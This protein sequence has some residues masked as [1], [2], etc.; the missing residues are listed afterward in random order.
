MTETSKPACVVLG[1]SGTIG[2]AVCDSLAP[3]WNVLG[4][5]RRG[6]PEDLLSTGVAELRV[7][8][9]SADA[10]AEI[11]G[12][13]EQAGWSCDALVVASGIHEVS[14]LAECDMGSVERMFA[15]NFLGP[16]AVTRVLLPAMSARRTGS[17]VWVSSVRGTHGDPGQ[18]VYAATKGAMNSA[19]YSLAREVGRRNVRA[20]IVAPGVVRSPMTDVLSYS[21][22]ESLIARNPMGR[23]AYPDEVATV[24][25]WLAGP[26]SS[27]VTGTIINVDC[28]EVAAGLKEPARQ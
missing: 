27:Y 7:D 25:R 1:A 18:V 21:W 2:S 3:Q 8:I 19:I 6:L 9:T 16:L 12:W 11:E 10:G 20:N 5:S 15:V 13:L 23:M 17:I 28:G 26:E 22:Q 24:V 4:V 14:L